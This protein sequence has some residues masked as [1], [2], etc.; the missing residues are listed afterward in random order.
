MSMI[1]ELQF[2]LCYFTIQQNSKEVHI[3]PLEM[4]WVMLLLT[5]IWLMSQTL[6]GH[7]LLHNISK[8]H[9]DHCSDEWMVE[10][11]SHNSGGATSTTATH[12][13]QQHSYNKGYHRDEL[14]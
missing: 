5:P 1:C 9:G 3:R 12:T 4:R 10:E 14:Q 6:F 8:T 7:A 2:L 13:R 11:G